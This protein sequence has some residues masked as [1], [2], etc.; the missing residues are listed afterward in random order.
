VSSQGKT[1]FNF[2][3]IYSMF[4]FLSKIVSLVRIF[5]TLEIHSFS[6]LF[7]FFIY[8]FKSVTFF[9]TDVQFLARNITMKYIVYYLFRTEE[10]GTDIDQL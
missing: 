5:F 3:L 8:K 10:G 2:L 6:P 4:V 9:N 1:N 7:S